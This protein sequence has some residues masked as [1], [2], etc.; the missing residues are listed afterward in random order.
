MN[1]KR[2]GIVII[3]GTLICISAW[4]FWGR[5][6]ISLDKVL[7]LKKDT[8]ENTVVHRDDM[9]VAK[10]ENADSDA[11]RPDDID[12]IIGMRTSQYVAGETELRKEYF[13]QSLFY[14]GEDTD[15]AVMALPADWLLSYPQTI[16]R[17]DRISLY[18]GHVRLIEAVVIHAKDS[19]GQEVLS[20]DSDRLSSSETV[21]TIEI[22]ADM[23]GLTD[24]AVLAG[25]GEKFTLLCQR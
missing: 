16:R 17:G 21:H 4:E 15:K 18:S 8:P 13:A 24:L 9:T 12:S 14:L 1:R 11:L 22:I 10:I 6:A 20:P 23:A 7:V 2:I 3:V 19:G 5:E 25:E